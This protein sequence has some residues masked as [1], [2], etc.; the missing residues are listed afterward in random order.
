MHFFAFWQYCHLCGSR[1]LSEKC[2]DES[3]LHNRIGSWY[4][5]KSWRLRSLN[6]CDRW[7]VEC[8]SWH[9]CCRCLWQRWYGRQWLVN[10][11]Q[12]FRWYLTYRSWFT[13]RSQS[14]LP[15]Q[16]VQHITTWASKECNELGQWT[17]CDSWRPSWS[18]LSR[19]AHNWQQLVICQC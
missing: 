9:L 12:K 14:K 4:C 1:I 10:H 17:L 5:K 11:R 15:Y 6:V 8:H 16:G 3:W 18:K 2:L 7:R 13:P 19:T